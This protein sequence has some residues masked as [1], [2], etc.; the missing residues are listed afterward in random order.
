MRI[1]TVSRIAGGALAAGILVIV[2]SGWLALQELRVNGPIYQRI[3]AG[4]DLIANVVPPSAYIIEAF[5]EATV[6]IKEPW[7]FEPGR[8]RLKL[9]RREYEERHAFWSK[10]ELAPALRNQLLKAA[11][12]PANY[13][14]QTV[15]DSFL[16][17]I[18]KGN[19]EAAGDAYL[20][21]AETYRAHRNAIDEVV[22]LARQKNSELELSAT[23]RERA[24]LATMAILTAIVVAFIV[25]CMLGTT[26]W[27]VG[28]IVRMQDAMRRLAGGDL[29]APVP[30]LDRK[31]EIGQMAGAVQV[32][33]D[34]A[35]ERNKL[36][37]EARLLSELNEWLQSCKSLDELY[38]MVGEFLSRLLPGCAGTLYVY[39][40]S[41]DVLETARV[42]NGG[43][44]TTAI[45]P[46]DC[47]GL[48]RGRTYAYGESEVGFPC[49]HVSSA[50][51]GDYCCIPILAH[52]ETI[53]MLHLEFVSEHGKHDETCP[54]ESVAER[55]R[56][57]LVCAEQISL[58]IANVKL[59]D[60]LR[61]QSIRDALTGMFN[62][63]YLLETCRREFSRAARAGQ[64]VSI[65]SIDVDHFKKFNDNHG[66]D[67]GDTVLRAVGDLM[68]N[69]FRDE[70][71]P[72]RFGGEE[73]V[74]LLPGA[75]AEVAAQ[76]AEEL[77]GRVEALIVRYVEAN[78][79]RITISIG[80][81]AFPCSGD[82]PQAVLKAAD[83][84]LYRAKDAGRNRVE[85]SASAEASPQAPPVPIVAMRRALSANFPS[86]SQPSE[87]IASLVTAA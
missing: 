32:F 29:E 21:L 14:W 39:A 1:T 35:M 62:R 82:S 53:G 63:R 11:H 34:N 51:V 6:I 79:P 8:K 70:D 16:P 9:L 56:L 48:R 84:A 81:A 43:Q 61:D 23:E 4:K 60:Q 31:D 58:A 7:T 68:K 15:E 65:L 87:D 72:C 36:N 57:G 24:I 13:F 37:R 85:L 47:W 75:T 50:D 73:F 17:A 19:A 86:Q 12:E 71:V 3:A 26:S 22:R 33:H 59:R 78:L 42:W 52:G 5:L 40:N 55:R 41:R 45:Q 2:G 77:R 49:A 54:K 74:V 67:A 69:S 25:A 10:Q 27:V 28:A 66:H 38:Q 44:S 76:K 80:V 64:S 20:Q 46:D 18:D 83:E 30:C